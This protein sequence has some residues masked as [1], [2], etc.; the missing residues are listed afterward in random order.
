[1]CADFSP[2]D[3]NYNSSI[4]PDGAGG[5]FVGVPY[6][7]LVYHV[8]SACKTSTYAAGFA[9][10]YDIAY[11][12]GDF[13][14]ANTWFC[15]DVYGDALLD[16]RSDGA[17]RVL[18]RVPGCSSSIAVNP[19]GGFTVGGW[20]GSIIN[21]AL[22]GITTTVLGS[23]TI[24]GGVGGVAYD[25]SG[26]LYLNNAG[27]GE[28][29]T[30]N[31]SSL[32]HF[33]TDYNGSSSSLF[34][35]IVHNNVLYITNAWSN[36]TIDSVDIPAGGTANVYLPTSVGLNIPESIGVD[37]FG[38]LIVEDYKDDGLFRVDAQKHVTVLVPRSVTTMLYPNGIAIPPSQL[39]YTVEEGSTTSKMWVIAP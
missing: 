8:N 37:G 19:S 15:D 4:I 22:T 33:A 31:G 34:K 26:T 32:T 39:I 18:A 11:L 16:V 12:N 10:P 17:V 21:V 28:I 27:T 29:L 38:N 35:M 9:D 3:T 6:D 2:W 25:N 23:G 1:M 36:S 13:Y 30:L 5:I 24:S 20:N 7:G 14:V